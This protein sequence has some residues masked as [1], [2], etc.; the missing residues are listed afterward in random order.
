[1]ELFRALAA[2]AEPPSDEGS[3]GRLCEVLGLGAAPT[4]SEYAEVFVFQL[5]PYASVYLGAEGMLGGEA[6][7][8]VAGFWRAL[9]QRPPVEA[10]HLAALLALYARLVE[11]EETEEDAARREGWRGARKALLW[12]HLLSWLGAYLDK[13]SE[14][15]PPSYRGWGELL[16]KALLAEVSVVGEQGALPAHLRDAEGLADPRAGEVEEFLQTLLAPARSGLILVRS[17]LSRAAR[18]LGLGA[19][20]G[21]RKFTLK[22]LLGQDAAGVLGWL[23]EEAAAWTRRHRA[24]REA[25]GAVAAWWESRAASSAALLGELA[26]EARAA[27]AASEHFSE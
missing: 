16:M 11:L 26:S 2:L 15:A 13:L 24:R 12:E 3:A 18:A 7:E 20:A 23:A 19:R 10:D 4:A 6:R 14:V 9:G 21:E 22:S 25:L 8:R 5:Y 1:M 27:S 17:D